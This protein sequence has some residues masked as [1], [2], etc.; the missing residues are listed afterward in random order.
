MGSLFE[1]SLL[2]GQSC[3]LGS[4]VVLYVGHAKPSRKL[5]KVVQLVNH[6]TSGNILNIA[7][8][9]ASFILITVNI[10]TYVQLKELTMKLAGSVD[11]ARRSRTAKTLVKVVGVVAIAAFFSAFYCWGFWDHGSHEARASGHRQPR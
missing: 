4:L 1:E 5:N 3:A 9:S 11:G 7:Y 10:L 2:Y 6:L 8:D